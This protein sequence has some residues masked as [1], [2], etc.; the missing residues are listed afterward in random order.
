MS[1]QSTALVKAQ[2]I[3]MS[4]LILNPEK[5]QAI[6][7]F[8]GM[9]ASGT[10]SVPDHLKG[11][12]SDCAAI[13]IQAIQWGGMNPF[14]VAQKTSVI[15]GTLCYEAQLVH[16]VTQAMNVVDG[17]FS[18][19][20][21]GPWDNVS[22]KW[23]QR[24]GKTGGAFFAPTWTKE[25]AKGVGIKVSAT[26][27][28]DTEPTSMTVLLTQVG[29]RH[30]GLWATDPEQQL[31][32]LAVKKFCRRNVPAAMLGV[33]T[34]DEITDDGE[35]IEAE[36][37]EEPTD[38]TSR[39]E[40]LKTKLGVDPPAGDKA[41]PPAEETA[42][43]PP[44]A[45]PDTDGQEPAKDP[46]GATPPEEEKKDEPAKRRRITQTALIAALGKTGLPDHLVNGW[47]VHANR[48]KEG[49]TAVDAS[50]EMKAW[51]VDN[52][53]SLKEHVEE[54]E[55]ESKNVPPEEETE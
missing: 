31:C 17:H 44:D 42:A 30:S 16:S 32:Y 52:P 50:S 18:F 1:E 36:V 53:E 10:V 21:V 45:K 14:V 7:N 26:L 3:Q 8:A 2:D 41:K 33:Y 20:P 27:R 40:A 37:I 6:D 43:T 24:Q 46:E 47:L 15:H 39:T 48:I 22:G 25:D 34:P 11:N 54:W 38:T 35:Y 4:D 5:M 28:G 49:Q 51:I 29:A 55:A 19:E 9:M 12:K 13:V 23:E